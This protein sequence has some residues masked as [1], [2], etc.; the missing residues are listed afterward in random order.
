MESLVRERIEEEEDMDDCWTVESPK[1]RRFEEV[2]L[3]LNT[4]SVVELTHFVEFRIVTRN[5]Q[6]GRV[7]RRDILGREIE[8]EREQSSSTRTAFFF[9]FF[10]I[11]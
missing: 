3:V 10:W 4:N 7:I 11:I 5:R 1:K 9:F 8:R 6:K 2:K